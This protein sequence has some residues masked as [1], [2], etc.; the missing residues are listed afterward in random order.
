MQF[1]RYVFSEPYLGWLCRGLVMT[2][3]ISA[4]SA[5]AATVV[6]FAVL[7]LQ[8]AAR[9]SVRALGSAFVVVFRN[10]PLVPLLLFL[11]FGLPSFWMQFVGQAFP[12]GHELPLL[13][14]GLSLNTGAYL[15]EILRAGVS[16]VP[17]GQRDVA[18]TLGLSTTE[19][20]LRVIYPQAVRIVA[21]ALATRLIHNTKNSALAVI[22]PLPV[23]AMELVGQAGRIAGQT[24]SWVEP[25]LMVAVLH[26]VLSSAV[27][28]LLLGWAGRAQAR[29][30]ARPA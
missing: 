1:G 3:L 14:A 2:V 10:V 5:V 12:R 24:F 13:L 28:A 16:G 22:V 8:L 21:P 29:V 4:V 7:H 18:R 9:R 26:L 19:I 23:T 25:L 17:S 11:T 20:R 6:G 27:G 15:T 30:E